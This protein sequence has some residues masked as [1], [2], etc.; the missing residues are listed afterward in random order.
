M[1]LIILL[2]GPFHNTMKWV[3][4][5][6]ECVEIDEEP[7]RLSFGDDYIGIYYWKLNDFQVK[8]VRQQVVQLRIQHGETC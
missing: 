7:Y 1:K 4:R 2:G 5:F 8:A 3:T 6:E